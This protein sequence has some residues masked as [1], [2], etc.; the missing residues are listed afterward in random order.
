MNSAPNTMCSDN[1]NGNDFEHENTL[2][3][4]RKFGELTEVYSS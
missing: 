1:V 4:L 3:S 2:H